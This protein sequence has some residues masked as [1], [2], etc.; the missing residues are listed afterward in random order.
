MIF[1]VIRYFFVILIVFPVYTFASDNMEI[2]P[3]KVIT[4]V[5]R[6]ETVAERIPF[7]GLIAFN[8]KSSISADAEGLITSIKINAGDRLK[9][10]EIFLT[11]NTDFIKNEILTI[12][13]Q[14]NQVKI[15]IEQA[16]KELQRFKALLKE[17]AVREKDYDD[18]SFDLLHFNREKEVLESRLALA[19]LKEKKSELRS[20]FEAV[21]L[22]KLTEV[23]VWV[24]PGIP[25]CILGSAEELVVNVPVDEHLLR[26][27]NIGD[28]VEITIS[29]FEKTV[30]G[31]IANII[32][33]ANERTK[34]VTLRISI[35][36]LEIPVENLSVTAYIPVNKPEKYFLVPR[37]AI[38][39]KGGSRFFYSIKDNKAV[40]IPIKVISFH[41]GYGL[42]R[43]PEV[44]GGMIAI[45]DGNE[46]LRPGQPIEIIGQR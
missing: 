32:P 44:T 2:P 39:E 35:P 1:R 34:A 5:V 9:K 46:R 6:E 15:R 19:K 26:F 40:T 12:N 14:I 27:S 37:D 11:L 25:L 7:E 22:S 13:A 31:K 36:P 8:L 41:K 23:G 29:A 3:A 33:V 30:T 45:V 21:V 18:A 38:I 43:D 20:P 28:D 16:E 24:S 17:N 10:D 42:V 4:S